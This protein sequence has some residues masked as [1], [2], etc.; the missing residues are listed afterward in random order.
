MMIGKIKNTSKSHLSS[1]ECF[2]NRNRTKE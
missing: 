2:V 1:E